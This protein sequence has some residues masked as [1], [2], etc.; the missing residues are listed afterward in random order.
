MS[1]VHDLDKN[2][3]AKIQGEDPLWV[4]VEA[5]G[6]DRSLALAHAPHLGARACHVG[7]ERRGPREAKDGS[8][9]SDDGIIV[10]IAYGLLVYD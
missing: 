2:D 1:C 8:V 6:N 4:H 10:K 3:R 7:R 9:D 5:Q